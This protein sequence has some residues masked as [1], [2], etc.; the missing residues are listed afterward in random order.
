MV[1]RLEVPQDFL[2]MARLHQPTS[3]RK[4]WFFAPRLV[5]CGQRTVVLLLLGLPAMLLAQ[6]APAPQPNTAPASAP[7]ATTQPALLGITIDRASRTTDIEAVVVQRDAPWLE[8]LACTKGSRE[9]EAILSVTAK[10]SHIH[11]ALLMLGLE[12]GTPMTVQNQPATTTQPARLITTPARGPL[13]RVSLL[14]PEGEQEREVSPSSWIRNQKTQQPLPDDRWLFTGSSI[15]QLD[16]GTSGYR[17]D[18]NGNIITLV[19][20]G[21][22]VLARGDVQMS[23]NNDDQAWG[24]VAEQIP[25]RGTKVKIRLRPVSP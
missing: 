19:Q 3:L 22:E 1:D 4:P 17:A 14:V 2:N 12:P 13:V 10:P 24:C 21:D 18:F 20:F 15:A 9:H 25:P 16:D 23:N 5:C 7:A 11:L 8:L 6:T